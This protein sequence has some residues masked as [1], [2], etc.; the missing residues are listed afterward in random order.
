MLQNN[1]V[2]NCEAFNR[3]V[4]GIF[5]Y[6]P[7]TN[8]IQRNMYKINYVYS[9]V[10]RSVSIRGNSIPTLFF[11]VSVENQFIAFKIYT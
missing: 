6:F 3:V 10:I 4:Y 7:C 9:T 1:R 8:N 2:Y 5:T 11:D